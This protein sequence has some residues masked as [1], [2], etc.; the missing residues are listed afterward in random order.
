LPTV[1]IQTRLRPVNF[2]AGA[3]I[4]AKSNLRLVSPESELRTVTLRRRSNE[5]SP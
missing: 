5:E 4:M 1:R 3:K 2:G